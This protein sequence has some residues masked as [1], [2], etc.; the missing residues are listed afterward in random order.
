[1]IYTKNKRDF[2]KYL[3]NLLEN[4]WQTDTDYLRIEEELRIS[5]NVYQNLFNETF[6]YSLARPGHYE[7][8]IIQ[9]RC[10]RS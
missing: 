4:W 2:K 3:N 9:K 8:N 7:R 1:M 10:Q 6:H 5:S